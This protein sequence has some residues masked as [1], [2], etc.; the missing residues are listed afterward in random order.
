MD[1]DKRDKGDIN[2]RKG[3]QIIN[4]RDEDYLPGKYFAKYLSVGKRGLCAPHSPTEPE[5]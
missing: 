1:N 3:R 4:S 5:S 2:K